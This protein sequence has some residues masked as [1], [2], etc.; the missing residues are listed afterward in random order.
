MGGRLQFLDVSSAGPKEDFDDDVDRDILA[1]VVDAA[2]S[3]ASTLAHVRMCGWHYTS[4]GVQALL[5][6]LPSLRTLD[7][8]VRPLDVPDARAMLR[9]A[10]PFA[11][12]RVWSLL[13]ARTPRGAPAGG[14][15]DAFSVASFVADLV[16]HPSVERLELNAAALASPKTV[17]KLVDAAIALRLRGLTLVD[18]SLT[19]GAVPQLT[20]LLGAGWLEELSIKMEWDVTAVF[21][22]DD[23]TA[24][25]C[26]AVKGSALKALNMGSTSVAKFGPARASIREAQKFV[27]RRRLVSAPRVKF[28]RFSDGDEGEEFEEFDEEDDLSHSDD[29][30]EE[31]EEEEDEEDD[32]W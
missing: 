18:C 2:Q 23:D 12:I 13:M 26:A 27:K 15:P 4:E 21:D 22:N 28:H 30:G 29:E 31:E 19:Q 24:R 14:L 17:E 1:L 32:E 16:A 3:N 11:P 20:R 25:F 5:R 10:P 6:A 9:N 8:D 7:I